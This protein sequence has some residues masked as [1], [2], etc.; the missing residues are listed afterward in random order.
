MKNFFKNYN[1]KYELIFKKI[2]IYLNYI[3]F[4]KLFLIFNHIIKLNKK[5]LKNK[6]N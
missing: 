5:K 1:H 6:T 4:F 3:F 2:L